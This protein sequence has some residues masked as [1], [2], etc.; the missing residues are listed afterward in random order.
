MN[1]LE[2]LLLGLVQGVTEFLP[3]SSSGHLVLA[4]ELL[5]VTTENIRF[6]VVVHLGSLLA[7]LAVYRGQVGRIV[8]GVFRGRV[9]YRRGRWTFS[10]PYTRLGWLLLLGTIPAGVVGILTGRLIA[11]F[12]YSPFL[13][14]LPV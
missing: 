8:R 6:M 13:V 2:A 10:D 4:E 14:V 9:R 12:F 3:V 1:V 5:G 11:N 7:V